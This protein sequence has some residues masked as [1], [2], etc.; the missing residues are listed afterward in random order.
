MG[1]GGNKGNDP[2]ECLAYYKSMF[3]HTNDAILWFDCEGK[4]FYTNPPFKRLFGYEQAE[5]LGQSIHSIIAPGNNEQ[6]PILAG[7][8]QGEVG[9]IDIETS[10]KTG[11]V[12]YAAV[13]YGPLLSAGVIEGG[14]VIIADITNRKQV[15]DKLKE[16]ELRLRTLISKAGIGIVIID[17]EHRIIEVNERFAQML[18]YS[19]EEL[20]GLRTWEWDVD[21]SEEEVRRVFR[22]LGKIN[23]YFKTRYQ[24]K[25]GTIFPVEINATGTDIGGEKTVICIC[26]DI[27]ERQRAEQ[28]LRQSEAKFRNFV[29]QASDII[30]TINRAGIVTY[31]SPNIKK[32]RGYRRSEVEGKGCTTYVHEDDANLLQRYIDKL[33]RLNRAY[34]AVEYRVRHK[35]GRWQ[36]YALTGSRAVDENQEPILICI[37]RNI[38]Y[39]KEYEEQLKFLSLHDQLTG[40][41]NRNYFEKELERLS[42][43]RDYP[44]SLL[45][46]DLNELK[47]V[48]DTLGHQAGDVLLKTCGTLLKNSLRASDIVARVGGDEFAAILL[49]TD[50]EM[51]AAIVSRIYR[52]VNAYNEK[53]PGVPLSVSIGLAT[54]INGLRPLKEVYKEADEQMY[55]VKNKFRQGDFGNSAYP[56]S[57]PPD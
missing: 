13:K 9:E 14:Y 38:T 34:R 54:A 16:Q 39:K 2:N 18:G 29:E 5:V 49:N 28:A 51:A 15:E 48:N 30:F 3:C 27:S 19:Q 52:N 40:L 1:T 20:L 53:K 44:I 56:F 4:I 26:Q 33:F 35:D 7:I 41:Y 6:P 8:F 25:D 57:F 47:V 43:S 17:Q 32:L 36:W 11:H 45:C 37:A 21:M 31:V 22:D 50:A 42:K 23:C 24:R 10:S 46:C 12:I 55:S